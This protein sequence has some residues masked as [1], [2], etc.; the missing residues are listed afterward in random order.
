MYACQSKT[1]FLKKFKAKNLNLLGFT[2][3]LC[4]ENRFSFSTRE[5]FDTKAACIKVF[6]IS[7]KF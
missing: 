2:Q 1:I 7:R 4:S 3:I 5:H 6:K